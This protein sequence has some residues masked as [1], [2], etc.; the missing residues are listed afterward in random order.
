VKHVVEKLAIAALVN[1]A[2]VPV[3]PLLLE[4]GIVVKK[5]F[6]G[7]EEFERFMETTKEFP[8]GEISQAPR[9]RTPSF[10]PSFFLIIWI[11]YS[12]VK[13]R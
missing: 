1:V 13:L 2:Y 3:R 10:G 8:Y 9:V 6:R 4:D 5:E 11:K 12:E 7:W